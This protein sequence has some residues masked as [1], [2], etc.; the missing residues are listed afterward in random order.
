MLAGFT[1]LV[2]WI[3]RVAESVHQLCY[4]S[5]GSTEERQ[6]HMWHFFE[7]CCYTSELEVSDVQPPVQQ[8]DR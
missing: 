8:T 4:Q 1:D 6:Q 7:I 2:V 3:S 5:S